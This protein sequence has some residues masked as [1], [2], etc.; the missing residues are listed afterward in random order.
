M[1]GELSTSEVSVEEPRFPFFWERLLAVFISALLGSIAVGFIYGCIAIAVS[2]FLDG[3][4][5]GFLRAP[6]FY[7]VVAPF[8]AGPIGFIIGFIG[9]FLFRRQRAIKLA[10][11]L[12]LTIAGWIVV[13]L[14]LTCFVGPDANHS[15][16]DKNLERLREL[17]AFF[18][19]LVS[20]AIC[21]RITKR[22]HSPEP[23]P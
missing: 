22:W 7:A 14:L 21:W 18:S 16:R 4:Q 15:L 8:I 3:F 1:M 11:I 2:L 5:I 12:G 20:A 9:M 23:S 10:W 13:A 19:V 17:S 6:F